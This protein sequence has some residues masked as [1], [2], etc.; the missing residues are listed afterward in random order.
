MAVLLVLFFLPFCISSFADGQTL[1][2]EG[3]NKKIFLLWFYIFPVEFD[4]LIKI[5]CVYISVEALK[6]IGKIL[7]KKWNFT[8]DPCSKQGNWTTPMQGKVKNAVTCNCSVAN[9]NLCRRFSLPPV[10][11]CQKMGHALFLCCIIDDKS[12]NSL[13]FLNSF[14]LWLPSFLPFFLSLNYI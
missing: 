13:F 10:L 7:G 4:L 8:V 6:D 3:K 12:I 14:H 1:A 5:L 11:L 9:D 2:E